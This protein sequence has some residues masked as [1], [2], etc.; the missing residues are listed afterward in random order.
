LTQHI[1]RKAVCPNVNLC[2]ECRGIRWCI[3]TN[4]SVIGVE[5]NMKP[6]CNKY[7]RCYCGKCK[8]EN[9]KEEGCWNCE[10]DRELPPCEKATEFV[11]KGILR[12]YERH[13]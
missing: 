4:S 12:T 3:K 13:D 11:R 8:M 7:L 9:K 6:I 1:N 5:E 2:Q 10:L